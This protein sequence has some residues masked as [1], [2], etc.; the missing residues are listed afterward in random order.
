MIQKTYWHTWKKDFL[1]SADDLIDENTKYA[2]CSV[3]KITEKE[4]KHWLS[5][6]EFLKCLRIQQVHLSSLHLKA[7]ALQSKFLNLFPMLLSS[8][9][10]KLKTFLKVLNFYQ[11]ITSIGSDKTLTPSFDH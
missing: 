5:Y 10:P 7:Y 6:N 8:F 4:K 1:Q 2:K 3:F 11:I 9:T